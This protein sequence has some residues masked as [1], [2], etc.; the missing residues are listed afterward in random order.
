MK[1][2]RVSGGIRVHI[3]VKSVQSVVVD[4]AFFKPSLKNHNE[5]YVRFFLHKHRNTLTNLRVTRNVTNLPLD[6]VSS[7][8]TVKIIVKSNQ[9]K[10]DE[11]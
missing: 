4:V 11:I 5:M 9:I 8:E 7:F 6:L 3:G 10:F 1:R 2:I